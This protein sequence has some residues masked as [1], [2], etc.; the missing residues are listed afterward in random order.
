M[1]A[2]CPTLAEALRD[3]SSFLHAIR[4]YLGDV[5]L[6]GGWVPYFYRYRPEC[7]SPAHG[8]LLSFDFDF[9]VPRDLPSKPVGSIRDLLLKHRFVEIRHAEDPIVFF[10]HSDR[11]CKVRAPV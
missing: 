10:Q 9:A 7:E 6:V 3:L 2:N 11:G 1:N 4:E 5:V 8:P